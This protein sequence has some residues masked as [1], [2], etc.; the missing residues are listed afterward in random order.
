MAKRIRSQETNIQTPSMPVVVSAPDREMKRKRKEDKGKGES[1]LDKIMKDE[2]E[3]GSPNS[4][5]DEMGLDRDQVIRAKRSRITITPEM[6]IV[7]RDI[8][9]GPMFIGI[10][11]DETKNNRKELIRL[12]NKVKSIIVYEGW[13]TAAKVCNA[14]L[15]VAGVDE[16]VMTVTDKT[17][18]PE[19]DPS[20]AGGDTL[21]RDKVEVKKPPTV[22]EGV[23]VVTEEKPNPKTSRIRRIQQIRRRGQ[24]DPQNV[25]EMGRTEGYAYA[26]MNRPDH[27]YDPSVDST[28]LNEI[29]DE[30]G[31]AQ[32]YAN[33]P[34]KVDS[35][36]NGFSS[37][38]NGYL[39][40]SQLNQG[41]TAGRNKA[42]RVPRRGGV[43]DNG[44][45]L[46]KDEAPPK[47][48][49]ELGV[50]VTDESENV[51]S[52]KPKG[53]SDSSLTK[54]DVD[55]K[56]S[57][58]EQRY[59]KLY[60]A[61]AEKA[62]Q[63]QVEAFARKF[64]KCIKIASARMKLNHTPHLLKASMVDVLTASD[65]LIEFTNGD[66]YRGM[67][68]RTAIELTELVASEGH[69]RFVDG[70][71]ADA[72]NLLEKSD[73]YLNDVES[74]LSNLTPKSVEA[75]MESVEDD[76]DKPRSRK[77]SN[78]RKRMSDGNFNMKVIEPPVQVQNKIGNKVGNALSDSTKLGRRLSNYTG[79]YARP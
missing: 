30:K 58:L 76:Y 14:K 16:D 28:I 13:K 68:D 74:D 78:I 23:E 55:F 40:D 51:Q 57:R 75:S 77:A 21:T 63:D 35:F 59:R 32:A 1:K 15:V 67:D 70:I 38:W 43:A 11:N 8:H 34:T 49:D 20:T 42:R 36:A 17:I 18:S 12:A 72:A 52:L 61:R 22:V 66:K 19:T 69:D 41:T 24:V 7:A 26:Q 39:N 3:K 2:D 65:G 31:Y 60:T 45:V 79:S 6:N 29:F 73:A 4:N 71:L 54:G 53:P 47:T 27:A 44:V 64:T 5:I 33:D 10:P 62:V 46:H 25:Y 50:S 56:T 9:R 37:G 48:T